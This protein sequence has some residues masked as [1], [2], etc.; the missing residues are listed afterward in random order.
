MPRTVPGALVGGQ[1]FRPILQTPPKSARREPGLGEL[2]P[3]RQSGVIVA[4]CYLLAC[5]GVLFVALMVWLNLSHR[6]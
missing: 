1:A 2:S 3:D 6:M 4:W 5:V